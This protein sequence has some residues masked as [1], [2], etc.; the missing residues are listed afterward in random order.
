MLSN[1]MCTYCA[2]P[3]CSI[4]LPR[5]PASLGGLI[6]DRGAAAHRRRCC[7]PYCPASRSLIVEL[8]ALFCPV[9]YPAE[10]KILLEQCDK[11]SLFQVGGAGGEGPVRHS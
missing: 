4:P 7:L 11:P 1:V 2:P 10:D 6:A 9:Y 3:R 8:N 5:V